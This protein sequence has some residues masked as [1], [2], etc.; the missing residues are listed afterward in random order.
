MGWWNSLV[1]G[2]FDNDGDIDYVAGNLGLNSNFKGTPAEPMTI[3]AKDLDNNGLVDPMLFCYLLAEDRTRKP[4][5]M[6]A[7][8]DMVSQMISMRKNIPPINLLERL[9]WMIYGVLK[10]RKMQ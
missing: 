4:F 9:L 6:H 8:E 1:A 10:T 5:P 3:Y 2:D 7:K